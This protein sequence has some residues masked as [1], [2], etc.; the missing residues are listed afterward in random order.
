[1]CSA[2]IAQRKSGHWVSGTVGCADPA[3]LPQPLEEGRVD[4][5][6]KTT[7]SDPGRAAAVATQPCPVQGFLQS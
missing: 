3:D 2:P 7:T 4:P 1:M 6:N 5:L